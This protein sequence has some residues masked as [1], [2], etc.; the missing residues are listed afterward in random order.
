MFLC[1]LLQ[2]GFAPAAFQQQIALSAAAAEQQT[3]PFYCCSW[4]S[5]AA[6]THSRA[7]A[8][9]VGAATRCCVRFPVPDRD[10]LNCSFWGSSCCML[11]KLRRLLELIDALLQ[12]LC[13]LQSLLL[14]PPEIRQLCGLS[15]Y[16]P[17]SANSSASCRCCCCGCC[18]CCIS[19]PSRL[20]CCCTSSC[21]PAGAC[22]AM[23]RK[24]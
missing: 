13:L 23:S 18:S 21:A 14:F 2:L 7:A 3:H 22:R 4:F 6:E 20:Y 19:F 24:L 10:L 12:R 8:V 15:C 11:S 9:S 16:T 1:L 17:L 5:A